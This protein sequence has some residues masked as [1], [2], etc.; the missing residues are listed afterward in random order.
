MADP[1]AL[2]GRATSPGY[3]VQK[4]ACGMAV[5]VFLSVCFLF[6]RIVEA[7]V[8]QTRRVLILNDIGIV[9]S[10]RFAEIDQALLAGLQKSLYQIELYQEALELTL[11][12]DEVSQRWFREEFTRQSAI[13]KPD[14]IITA[15]SDSVH[16]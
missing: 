15:G 12:P 16:L 13:R 9:S 2:I 11:F 4:L 1:D 10:P 7:Q 5:V 3:S 14:V 6:H 8:K